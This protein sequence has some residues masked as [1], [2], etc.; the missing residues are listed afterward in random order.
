[1]KRTIIACLLAL[2]AA[3]PAASAE[4]RIK[5]LVGCADPKL[6]AP[7][8]SPAARRDY[9]AKLEEARKS[10]NRAPRA[11]DSFIWLGRRTAYLGCFV[12]AVGIYTRGLSRHPRDAR[13]YRHRGH[14]YLTLRCFDLAVQ[15]FEKAAK[16]L[17][18]KP[19]EIEPDGLPNA[20]GVP[21]ST[22]KSN[23]FY[24]LGLAHYLRGDFEKALAAYRECLKFSTN[25]DMLAATAHWF[26][27]TLR[28]TGR[29]E[30]A[31]KL[32]EKIDDEADIIENRDYQQLLLMYKGKVSAERLLEAAAV[33]RSS[34]SYATVAYGVGSRHVY[35]GQP[36][37]AM[38]LFVELMSS[39][40]QTSFG[41]IAA[42]AE[43]WRMGVTNP[44][45][46]LQRRTLYD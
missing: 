3:A 22:L 4:T 28:R 46:S 2:V 6:E 11:A 24:H 21:T 37:R 19:D 26:Y 29:H 36:G 16:L 41:Y 9:E 5:T 38:S 40:Q 34:V 43:L 17:E 25:A 32:L 31:A 30:E 15:D 35:T 33:D 39:P 42:E 8:L 23:V 18:G 14:R 7:A 27:M 1:M 13:L 44:R 10:F 12:E 45:Q 20:R